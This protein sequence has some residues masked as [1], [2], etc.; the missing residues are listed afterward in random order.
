[1]EVSGLMDNHWSNCCAN[2]LNYCQKCSEKGCT[3]YNDYVLWGKD[4]PKLSFEEWKTLTLIE[5]REAL[6]G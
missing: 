4:N 2:I 1:M 5:Y 3:C 6:D